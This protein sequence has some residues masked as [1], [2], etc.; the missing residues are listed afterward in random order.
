MSNP[1]VQKNGF[2]FVELAIV[3]VILG[4]L[5]AG[6]TVGNNL[7]KQAALR[8]FMRQVDETRSAIH[9]F[10]LRYQAFPGDMKD[11][12]AYWPVA[13]GT[14]SDS[15][16]YEIDSTTLADPRATCNGNGSQRI[17]EVSSSYA[18]NW[19]YAERFRLWQ[20]LSNAG[21]ISGQFTGRTGPAHNW[22]R[23]PGQ[24]LPSTSMTGNALN[25]VYKKFG[26]DAGQNFS[27]IFNENFHL[28][29]LVSESLP[30]PFTAAELALIDTKLDDGKPATGK[31][32]SFKAT[33][34]WG[35]G[36]AT[37][38]DPVTALYDITNPD[39]VCGF[40]MRL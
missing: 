36:C 25:I 28:I 1:D 22:H 9:L 6:I 29:S 12:T 19:V 26:M 31:I 13:G 37:S 34:T 15:V 8:S 18:D 33:S 2:T 5:T 23:M 32:F 39:Q 14:G 38:D 16:C 35:P 30:P 20:H 40:R 17:D 10:R 24:N 3:M 11:A 27:N 7:M 4:L 21:M